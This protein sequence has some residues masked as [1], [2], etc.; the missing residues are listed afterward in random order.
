MPNVRAALV[1]IAPL[2]ALGL[3]CSTSSDASES[4]AV[5]P[6]AAA[7]PP[8]E[9]SPVVFSDDFSDPNSGWTRLDDENAVADYVDGAYQVL[10][11][12]PDWQEWG[13]APGGYGDARLEV[14]A[15]KVGGSDNNEFGLMCRYQDP[16]N[17]YALMINSEGYYGIVRIQDDVQE[18]LGAE[19]QQWSEAILQGEATNHIRADCVGDRLTLYVNG[20]EIFSAQD[21]TW[22]AGDVGVIAGGYSE[23]GTDIRFD[24]YVVQIP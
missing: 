16:A 7:P 19:G 21:S 5:P 4:S 20:Q 6:T 14:D 22:T 15:T 9:S 24:N 8:T 11:R 13:L 3:A 1:F 12:V 18:R 17:F 10:I 2:V 23:P